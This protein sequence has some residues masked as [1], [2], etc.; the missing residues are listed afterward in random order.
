MDLKT[1]I[2]LPPSVVPF[3]RWRF[4]LVAGLLALA[5]VMFLETGSSAPLH[6]AQWLF[7]LAVS[8]VVVVTVAWEWKAFGNPRV[9]ANAVLHVLLF[10]SLACMLLRLRGHV[11]EKDWSVLGG[12]AAVLDWTNQAVGLF[13]PV[14]FELLR[15]PGVALLFFGVCLALCFRPSWALGVLVSV[16]ILGL[17]LSLLSDDFGARSW[18]FGGL[19]CFALS[20]WLQYAPPDHRNFWEHVRAR[21]IGDDH[22]RGDLELKQRVLQLMVIECRPLTEGE[23][24]GRVARALGKSPHDEAAKACT[25]R[26]VAQL[27]R[28]DGVCELV[29]GAAGPML[30]LGTGIGDSTPDIFSRVAVVPKLAVAGLIALVWIISPIDLIP[31]STPFIGTLD[32][33]AVGLVVVG[34][35]V[36]SFRRKKFFSDGPR[37][38]SLFKL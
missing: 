12:I 13:P 10:V 30:G 20:L 33:V 18:F 11:G 19:A 6:P 4:W 3:L 21:W 23:C 26:I 32:D 8:F 1:T 36:R 15:S 22:V 7:C 29:H 27:V 24:L 9:L 5:S 2:S 35:A 17:S 14:L 25:S 34:M 28:E 37:S 38:V 31:D 16:F